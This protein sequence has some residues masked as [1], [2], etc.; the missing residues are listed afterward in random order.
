MVRCWFLFMQGNMNG[1]ML[2]KLTL[3]ETKKKGGG[4]GKTSSVFFFLMFDL[5]IVVRTT[6]RNSTMVSQADL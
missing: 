5:D 6:I 3:D 1:G 2:K 4:G